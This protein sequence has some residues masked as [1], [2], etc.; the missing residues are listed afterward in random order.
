MSQEIK[1]I[2]YDIEIE[3]LTKAI[4]IKYGYDFSE[5]SEASFKRRINKVMFV[6]R[7]SSVGELCHRIL[8]DELFFN[9]FLEEITVNITEMFRDPGFYKT[10]RREVL[11]KLSTFS[12]IRIWH[13][14][15][16]TGEEVYSMAILLKEAGLLEKSL[17]YA[18]DINQHVLEKAASSKFPIDVMKGYEDNYIASGGLFNLSDYYTLEH[19]KAVFYQ[20]FRKRMVFSPHNLVI[21]QG[22]N[23]FNLILCRNVLIYFNRN[24]QNRAIRL[25]SDSL[26]PFGFLA[27][28]SKESVDFTS[29]V[30]DFEVINKQ[31][32][33][34]G[35]KK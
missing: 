24:L 8:E 6:Y 3:S 14:G 12:L 16:S 19:N 1:N 22:F 13:A 23:E 30:N 11:P 17:L 15:C 34:W 33:I 4:F 18:T 26:P 28:G 10:L 9:N 27:L 25:F 31:H 21:D 5:Y 2:I 32:R 35:K 7:F 29:S 20:E